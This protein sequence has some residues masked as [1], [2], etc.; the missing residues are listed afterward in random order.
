MRSTLAGDV[1]DAL[2]RDLPQA[3]CC[4]QTLLRALAYYGGQAGHFSTQRPA[5]AR[6][7]HA[8]Q[9]RAGATAIR[10]VA[11]TRLYRATQY[12]AA[13]PPGLA[14][15]DHLTA[16]LPPRARRRCCRRAELRGAFLASGS[17]S[18]PGKGYHLEFALPNASAANRLRAMLAAEGPRPKEAVRRGRELLYFKDAESVVALL[19][20][21]GAHAA[22][23]HLE[24]V[25]AVKETK[26]RIH[27][28]V[29]VEAANVARA[30]AAATRQRAAIELVRDAYGLHRLT[31]ALRE[32]A[33]LRLAHPE[34]TLAELAAL[35][36]PEASRATLNSRLQTLVRLARRLGAEQASSWGTR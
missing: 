34:L 21:I 36:R 31:P 20:A 17:L 26:N 15:A 4:R 22:V 6:L 13:L 7:F 8:L 12:V 10:A 16:R 28:L 32:A 24:D 19:G 14:G 3:A 1:K 11:G 33:E 35:C 2:A 23:L 29:N 9:P 30:V 25:R 18:L 5:I 27:R